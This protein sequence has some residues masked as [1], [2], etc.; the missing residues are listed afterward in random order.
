MAKKKQSRKKLTV[1]AIAVVALILAY[2]FWPQ[3]TLVDM[4][5]VRR[6]SMMLTINEEARTQ[7][8]DAYVVSAP[9]SGRLVRVDAEPN[10]VVEQGRT[11]VARMLP[12]SPPA[13]DV[14]QHEQA[15]AAVKA[16]EAALR[17]ARA[18]LKQAV[19]H[20]EN[21][22]TN[23]ERASQQ[24]NIG[25][26]SQ[27]DLEQAQANAESASAAVE[28]TQAAIAMREAE[29]SN[30]QAALIGLLDAGS[31]PQDAIE[32][33]APVNGRVLKVDQRSEGVITAGTPI[34]EIGN[35]GNDLEVIVELLSTDAV[36]VSKGDK[37]II[38][39]WGGPDSLTG[40]VQ[41]VDPYGYTKYSALGVEEQ[42]V[43]AIIRFDD[44][45][46]KM[47]LGHGFRVEVKIVIWQGND[48]VMVPSSALFRKNDQ[49]A[50]FV[51][52]GGKAR[53]RNVEI[54]KNN[55]TEASVVKGLAPQ[56]QVVLY[57][58]SELQ[59]GTS[60]NNRKDG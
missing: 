55:G 44:K 40:T 39:N 33:K 54:G 56:D 10:D 21:S 37:V 43:N 53:L 7:V 45:Q 46:D 42:R 36:Q 6:G 15:N 22:K 32:I 50:V 52:D 48:V 13:L 30:A 20:N 34:L 41:R 1:G 58:A 5:E 49:W 8:R 12:L 14:R 4:G 26:V 29:L 35:V 27:S 51:V 17:A 28:S 2:A 59:D 47:N 9:I 16:A 24:R 23:V 38:D 31:G 57:P 60:V 11:T 3:A 18:E 25:S 19:V